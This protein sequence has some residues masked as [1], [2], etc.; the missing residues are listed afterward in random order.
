MSEKGSVW[1]VK[2]IYK[3][4][5]QSL[6]AIILIPKI[7]I[8]YLIW[9]HFIL[10]IEFKKFPLEKWTQLTNFLTLKT[11]RLKQILILNHKNKLK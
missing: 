11:K 10:I 3:F 9:K 8:I 7:F 1:Y 5:K 6:F 4:I 2:S